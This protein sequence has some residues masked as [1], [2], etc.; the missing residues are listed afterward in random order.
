M[1]AF[2]QSKES[3]ETV[4]DDVRAV[5]A[6]DLRAEQTYLGSCRESAGHDIPRWDRL[7]RVIDYLDGA[8]QPAAPALTTPAG[9]NPMADGQC[10]V[11][12]GLV[13]LRAAYCVQQPA[14]IPDQMALVWRADVGRLIGDYSRLATLV[15][16]YIPDA[17]IAAPSA[18]RDSESSNVLAPVEHEASTE[19]R[20]GRR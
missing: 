7:Q 15:G 18:A 16:K 6:S 11:E 10:S 5:M 17:Y 13:R 3:S 12:S 14:P 20:R 1:K 19:N 9:E 2:H 4:G 8:P